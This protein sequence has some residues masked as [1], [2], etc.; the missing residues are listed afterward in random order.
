[1]FETLGRRAN[2]QARR[3]EGSV[4]EG[5]HAGPAHR[6]DVPQVRGAL[7]AGA[8]ADRGREQ[9][10]PRADARHTRHAPRARKQG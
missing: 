5:V 9:G 8:R 4:P 2:S 6:G 7:G 1:M 10:A 3:A